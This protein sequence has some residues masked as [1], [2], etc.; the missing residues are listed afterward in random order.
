M[1][2]TEYESQFDALIRRIEN[3][4]PTDDREKE[5]F[6]IIT[7]ILRGIQPNPVRAD[8]LTPITREKVGHLVQGTMAN[9]GAAGFPE[10]VELFLFLV[11]CVREQELRS[12]GPTSGVWGRII[13]YFVV[14]DAKLTADEKREW[15]YVW[16]GMPKTIY[17]SLGEH[18]RM[19]EEAM[20]K[21]IADWK[22][23]ATKME[24]RLGTQMLDMEAKLEKS[25]AVVTK[26]RS[27]YNFVGLAKGF[28]ELANDKEEEEARAFKLLTII[29]GI[30]LVPVIARLIPGLGQDSIFE[31]SKGSLSTVNFGKLIPLT[32]LEIILLYF[33]RI[34]LQNYFS[35]RAQLVQLKLRYSL[36]Q[37]V[38]AYADFA[39]EHSTTSG[40]QSTLGRFEGL[41]FSSIVLDS[42]KVPATIDGID[43]LARLIAEAR[44]KPE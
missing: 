8:E 39:K 27:D 28:R 40:G 33:F 18:I 42:S 37:F 6:G 29:G 7:E 11:R 24:D 36:C 25:E 32:L 35:L 1:K 23:E 4:A 5:R 21:K 3:T 2:F 13:E 30:M 14:N 34:T 10:L 12:T 15:D 9:S 17:L 22:A 31:V 20:A 19:I 26:F 41:I 38:E 43:Q 16:N 44:R